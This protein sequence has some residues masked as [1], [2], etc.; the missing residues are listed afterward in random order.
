MNV[1]QTDAELDEFLANCDR[2][3][4]VSDAHLRAAFTRVRME[5]SVE[6]SAEP[7]SEAY[8][9]E[10]MTL[11]ERV[12]NRRYTGLEITLFDVETTI[13]WPFPES[14][15]SPRTTGDHYGMIGFFLR[16]MASLPPG[17]RIVEF[18]P[19]WGNLTL[20]MAKLGFDVTAVDVDPGFCHLIRARAERA[21]LSIRVVQSDFNWAETV[22]EPF[23]AAVYFECF[24][25]CPDHL[26]V[27][28]ALRNAV[29][30]EGRVFFGGE[31]IH[32]D[33]PVPWGVRLDGQSLWAIRQHGHLEL[34]FRSDYFRTALAR[35]GWR[36][37]CVVSKD[38]PWMTVWESV[39][40]DQPISFV[41]T[42]PR[43][44]TQIGEPSGTAMRLAAEHAA[45]GLYG[46]YVELPAGSYRAV[47]VFEEDNPQHGKALME[48]TTDFGERVVG[49]N[50]VCFEAG[51]LSD[52][53]V[54]FTLAGNTENVEVRLH[55]DAGF[56]A[57]VQRIE[58]WP[59]DGL[60]PSSGTR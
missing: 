43:I 3:G 25:H 24:H 5:Y 52:A 48:V 41:A 27:L 4:S 51:P 44:H 35:T 32:D 16:Q 49:Q 17:A 42:D 45:I 28:R 10:Q 30:P 15:R 33:F 6:S 14:T 18:G 13:T 34:G 20:M 23:D 47:L 40:A 38:I 11:F 36:G 31:P 56:V 53:A 55:C 29:K 46:P 19:G 9:L 7:L 22:S 54:Y 58:I 50:V 21:N 2:A 59:L 1:I 57:N 60:L 12:A 26:R 37:S 8:R 39:R